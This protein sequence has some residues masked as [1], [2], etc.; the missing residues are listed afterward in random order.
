MQR[1]DCSGESRNLYA[2]TQPEISNQIFA[3]LYWARNGHCRKAADLAEHLN[4]K[5][6]EKE[7][8]DYTN[9]FNL[10]CVYSRCAE[11]SS[12]NSQNAPGYG[13]T[14]LR[15]YKKL[16]PEFI[17]QNFDTIRKDYDIAWL[18][19]NKTDEINKFHSQNNL[20]RI[21]FAA[22]ETKAAKTSN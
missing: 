17:N 8:V 5:L 2:R 16:T 18:L 1:R 4:S 22:V 20:P 19:E 9:I 15:V 14:A 11:A 21:V 13:D 6:F 7:N 12:D 3:A 10:A